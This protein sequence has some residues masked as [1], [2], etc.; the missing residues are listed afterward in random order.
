MIS[1]KING[2]EIEAY[3][4]VPSK[5]NGPGIL[6]LHAW[7]GLND[8][9]KSFS[10]RLVNEGYLVLTP[11]LYNKKIA[12]SIKEAELFRNQVDRKEINRILK[13]MV[14]FLVKHKNCTS[15][16]LTVIGFSLGGNWASWLANNKP[17]E[18]GKVVLF[19]ATGAGT[20]AKTK[21]DFLCH[22]A[23]T[24]SYVSLKSVKSFKERLKKAD[25]KANFYEYSN[26]QHWFF[27][28]NQPGYYNE[29]ASQ[30][31]WE[32]TLQFIKH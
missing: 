3:F 11:D 23:E 6:V 21:A 22:F 28:T 27:E 30:K 9:F 10:E 20:F 18:I 14:N 24:D 12:S 5:K 19:Y 7:W 13:R 17:K 26:T 2:K 31:A 29:E 4:G 25:I 8:F 15:P 16:R 32:R 1:I